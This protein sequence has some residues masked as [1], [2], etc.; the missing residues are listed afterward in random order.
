MGYQDS[1]CG[2]S[3][4][5][6]SAN[7]N[8]PGVLMRENFPASKIGE[9]DPPTRSA[10]FF[11]SEERADVDFFPHRESRVPEKEAREGARDAIL[12]K[13][14]LHLIFHT[15]LFINLLGRSSDAREK[16]EEEEEENLLGLE[17]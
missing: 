16:E 15:I 4:G 7:A 1:L 8:R 17:G 9:Q 10:N 3:D 13:I 12:T 5:Y 14:V 11:W 2:A 6:A